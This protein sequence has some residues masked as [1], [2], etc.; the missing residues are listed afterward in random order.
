MSQ[1]RK[2]GLSEQQLLQ[3]SCTTKTMKSKAKHNLQDGLSNY[4]G[5]GLTT[6]ACRGYQ[7]SG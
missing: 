5:Q 1:A 3:N 4:Q 2:Q 6:G 7:I